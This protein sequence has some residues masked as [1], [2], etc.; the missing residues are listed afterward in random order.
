MVSAAN[1]HGHVL[2]GRKT[3]T[4]WEVVEPLSPPMSMR[5]TPERS[6]TYRVRNVATGEFAFLKAADAD[7]VDEDDES[8]VVRLEAVL[9]HHKF[10]AHVSEH[11]HGNNMDRVCLAIDHGN[12]LVEFNG[13]KEPV[14]FLVF[15]LADGDIRDQIF[16]SYQWSAQQ[17]FRLLHH[18]SVGLSQLHAVK[19]SHNDLKPPNVLAYAGEHKVADLG[20]ATKEDHLAPH[21]WEAI[22]GDPRYAPPEALY[23]PDGEPGTRLVANR[24]RQSGDLY[25]LGSLTYY[26]FSG[27]MMTPAI[28]DRMLLVHLPPLRDG[29]WTGSYADLLPYWRAA[30]S[31]EMAVFKR[32]LEDQPDISASAAQRLISMIYQLC[33]PDPEV[34][35]HPLDRVLGVRTFS[36][37]RFVAAFALLSRRLH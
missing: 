7:M 26:L 33:E 24:L 10:E 22:V 1:L 21:D 23:L 14:F 19:V 27:R 37:Q 8:L 3:G 29:G 15:E 36:L 9:M 5:V 4:G 16:T 2:K 11:C 13:I 31:E 12:T 28:L 17:K 20:Q 18:V 6:H 30:F 34:R 25:L 32:N 35:G